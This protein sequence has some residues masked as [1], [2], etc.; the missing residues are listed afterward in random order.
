MDTPK[1]MFNFILKIDKFCRRMQLT[2]SE[3][4]KDYWVIFINIEKKFI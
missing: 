4:E 3:T 1:F 2:H